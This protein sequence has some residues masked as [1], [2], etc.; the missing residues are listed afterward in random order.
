ETVSLSSFHFW[1]K[2]Q[3]LCAKLHHP[4]WNNVAAQGLLINVPLLTAVGLLV[5][6]LVYGN[7]QATL[8]N[9]ASLMAYWNV[10]FIF[11]VYSY[12]TLPMTRNH[13]VPISIFD[14]YV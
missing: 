2:R 1:V 8:W 6:G 4:A 12:S 10:L 3:L 11:C 9:A 14:D 7:T 5:A 13:L